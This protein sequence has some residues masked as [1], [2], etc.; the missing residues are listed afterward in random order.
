V[1]LLPS[2]VRKWCHISIALGLMVDLDI[3]T[4][5]MRWIG[6][7]RFMIGFLKGVAVNKNFQCRL[8]MKVV[9]S[10]KVEMARKAREEVQAR[11]L[12]VIGG[13][14]TPNGIVK[15]ANDH[16]LEHD[17]GAVG[18]SN[19][20]NVEHGDT[21]DLMIATNGLKLEDGE[22]ANGASKDQ[23]GLMVEASTEINGNGASHSKSSSLMEP[24]I[25]LEDGALP[26]ARP[27]D[28]DASWLTI[29]SPTKKPTVNIKVFDS[30]S[31]GKANEWVDGE[32]ILYV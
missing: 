10:D 8:R 19:G 23:K 31:S 30:M 11:Q 6:D 17:N 9:E 20:L 2:G 16:H 26:D 1:L 32:G 15:P 27:L 29:E 14:M 25:E 18:S 7:T 28:M 24:K 12:K 5:H 4:E 21:D 3:G 13:G 22:E